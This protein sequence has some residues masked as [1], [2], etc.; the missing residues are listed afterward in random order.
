V[1]DAVRL[2]GLAAMSD[3]EAADL[4]SEFL[5][6]LARPCPVVH[7]STEVAVACVQNGE[8]VDE[9]DVDI[10]G[11]CQVFVSSQTAS[12]ELLFDRPYDAGFALSAFRC[13][14]GLE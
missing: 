14:T 4:A 12:V 13:V 11:A 7:R 9:L 6:S 2:I 8:V 1:P 3:G 5:R 10:E